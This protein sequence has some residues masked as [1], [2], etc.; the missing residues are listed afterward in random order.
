M[1][2]GWGVCCWKTHEKGHCCCTTS[3]GTP[4]LLPIPTLHRHHGA[5]HHQVEH[6]ARKWKQG[7]STSLAHQKPSPLSRAQDEQAQVAAGVRSEQLHHKLSQCVSRCSHGC[8]SI[9]TVSTKPPKLLFLISHSHPWAWVRGTLGTPTPPSAHS[10]FSADFRPGCSLPCLRHMENHWGW[11]W[12]RLCR[13]P[14]PRA[15]QPSSLSSCVY[16]DKKGK[17]ASQTES[18]PF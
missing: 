7:H 11:R 3:L 6:K 13:Q 1:Y 18:E 5:D 12:W 8:S 16:R 10:R 2:L 17:E 4:N 9:S 15:D 14:I